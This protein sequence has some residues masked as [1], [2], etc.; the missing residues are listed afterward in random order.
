MRNKIKETN[1]IKSSMG[2]ILNNHD[3]RYSLQQIKISS[4]KSKLE[5]CKDG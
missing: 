3:E 2:K 5:K 4:R 1:K